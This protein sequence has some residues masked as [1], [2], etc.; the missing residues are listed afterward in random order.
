VD[1]RDLTGGEIACNPERM[2]A[3]IPKSLVCID[4]PDPRH[5]PLVEQRGFDEP[6]SPF[7]PVGELPRGEA[8]AKRLDTKSRRQ[9]LVELVALEHEPGAE[10]PNVTVGDIRAVVYTDNSTS[11]G[12]GRK[13]PVRRDQEAPRH[14]EVN[15]QDETTLE[16]DN[17]ILATPIDGLD[18]LAFESCGHL[19]RIERARESLVEDLD[20]SE[21][22]A[23]EDRRQLGSDG[24][25]LGQL[26]HVR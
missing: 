10:S 16:P 13:L 18:A 7:Q 8:W 6:P 14:P 15:Q 17:Y 4:V 12:I 26:G 9:V 11:M 5:D 24:L 20:R 19:P 25:D 21:R 2:N 23:G 22:T 1:G 3:G